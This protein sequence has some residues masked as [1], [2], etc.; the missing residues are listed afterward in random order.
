[1]M[2]F[3]SELGGTWSGT[4]R[5]GTVSAS[6]R[7]FHTQESPAL[8]DVVRDM[9]KFSNNVIARQLFLTIGAGTSGPPARSEAARGAIRQWVEAKGIAAPELVMENGSGLSR[10][11]R[12]SAA[13]LAGLLQAAWRSNVMP[14]FIA[15][16]PVAAVDGTMRRRLRK[17]GVAGNAH[18][19]TGL[20]SDVRAMAGY[21]RDSG[22]R[23]HIVVMLVNHPN[24]HQSQAALDA[25]L[26]WV[27]EPAQ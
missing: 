24:A 1:M 10:L 11:E 14:E 7:L 15:S 20:L 2:Q 16:M 23:R 26:R 12:I 22:G 25:L 21:V 4:V 18:V 27:Y 19:K 8:A 9:N 13:S 6:A 5:E 3:W 17:E